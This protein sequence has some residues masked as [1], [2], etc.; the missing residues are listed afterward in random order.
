MAENEEFGS[1]LQSEGSEMAID[2]S[3][4]EEISESDESSEVSS[5]FYLF[6]I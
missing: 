2:L 3:L 5:C 1:V 4:E 6:S